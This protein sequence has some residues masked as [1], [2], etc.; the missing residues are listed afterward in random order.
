MTGVDSQ[1]PGDQNPRFK[2]H[3]LKSAGC[4]YSYHQKPAAPWAGVSAFWIAVWGKSMVCGHDDAFT[5]ADITI[6]ASVGERG[7]QRS[8]SFIEQFLGEK[9]YGSLGWLVGIPADDGALIASCPPRCIA[10]R[11]CRVFSRSGQERSCC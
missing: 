4:W 2:R 7:P 5:D 9:G 10:T 6:V 1:W 11:I 8:R 3:R